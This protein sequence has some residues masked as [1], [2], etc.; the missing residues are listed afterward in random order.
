MCVISFKRD[1]LATTI[2]PFTWSRPNFSSLSIIFIEEKVQYCVRLVVIAHVRESASFLWR[3][4][5]LRWRLLPK[6]L[7]TFVTLQK[8]QQFT[9]FKHHGKRSARVVNDTVHFLGFTGKHSWGKINTSATQAHS[10]QELTSIYSAFDHDA[11]NVSL[12][13]FFLSRWNRISVNTLDD[14]NRR[15]DDVW[16]LLPVQLCAAAVWFYSREAAIP[17]DHWRTHRRDDLP[18]DLYHRDLR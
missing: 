14:W 10:G 9:M 5:I 18:D 7:A 4:W 2:W 1:F 17:S 11:V 12:F 15:R 3:N 13:N 6:K 16:S 8:I